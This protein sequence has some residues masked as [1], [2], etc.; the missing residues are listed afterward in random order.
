MRMTWPKMRLHDQ[1][2]LAPDHEE[3]SKAYP[4]ED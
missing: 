1:A 3:G 4:V 2:H